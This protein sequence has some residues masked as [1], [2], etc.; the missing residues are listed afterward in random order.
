MPSEDTRGPEY[1]RPV[2]GRNGIHGRWLVV[3]RVTRAIL[4]YVVIVILGVWVFYAVEDVRQ[5]GDLA[6]ATGVA[7]ASV[8]GFG[9]AVLALATVLLIPAMVLTVELVHRFRATSRAVRSVI[10][11]VSWAG[12]CLFVASTLTVASRVVLVPETLAGDLFLF[13]ASGAGFSL[14]AF[15]GYAMR[16]GKALTLLALVVTAF[17]V[18]GSIW[19]AGR[20]GSPV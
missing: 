7:A 17:F 8:L 6:H 2:V 10:G 15:D 5:G 11:A 20:W 16:P 12:W 14:L 13:A 3:N 1:P 9:V 4:A 18:L 19:M